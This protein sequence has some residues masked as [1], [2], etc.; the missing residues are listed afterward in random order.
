[1]KPL[2][3]RAADKTAPEPGEDMAHEG[4]EGPEL[5][6]DEDQGGGGGFKRMADSVLEFVPEEFRDAAMRI[7]AAG[8]KIM[9]DPSMRD[10]VRK[11]S[12]LQQPM[13][14]KLATLTLA[15]MQTVD[16]KA[17]GGLPEEALYPAAVMLMGEIAGAL[18]SK[19]EVVSEDDFGQAMKEI[20]PKLMAKREAPPER[21]AELTGEG[22]E[23]AERPQPPGEAPPAPTDD[24]ED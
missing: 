17:N 10:D 7:H 5:E 20:S 16:D 19:G 14:E 12:E 15:L 8:L 22:Q 9:T 6:A 11:A 3:Q 13:P 23:Q 21:I 4:A 1:M 18:E 2:M 24:W